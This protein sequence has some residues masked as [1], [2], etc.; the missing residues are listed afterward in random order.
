MNEELKLLKAALMENRKIIRF[1]SLGVSLESFSDTVVQHWKE[2]KKTVS[3][4]RADISGFRV[5][6]ADFQRETDEALL[7]ISERGINLSVKKADVVSELNAALR[8][9]GNY[10]DCRAKRFLVDTDNLKITENSLS[11]TGT[12]E[13]LSCNIGGFSISGS[14][15]NG[16]EETA[17]H[18]GTINCSSM[19]MRHA[20]ADNIECNPDGISGKRV[21]L[22]SLRKNDK[23]SKEET[24]TLMSGEMRVHGNVL[25]TEGWKR[26]SEYGTPYSFM[27]DYLYVKGDIVLN[28]DGGYK[29][30]HRLRVDTI[31]SEK[32]GYEWSDRRYKEDIREIPED[33]AEK[34]FQRIRPVEFMLRKHPENLHYG[35]IAQEMDAAFQE[36]GIPS[37]VASGGEYLGIAYT[38]LIPF[39]IMIIQSIQK[40]LEVLCKSM[41]SM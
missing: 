38:E 33:T 26:S 22:T 17:I 1:A 18:S 19:N 37:I 12:I 11:F 34:F 2:N 32:S 29:I 6:Y 23:E 30:Q 8:I 27:Y 35:Y 16:N 31:Y 20:I 41:K 14:V 28:S 5:F 15:M 39:R 24:S 13:G 7:D 36:A 40:K 21:S 10:I 4:L 25:A 9:D 3:E